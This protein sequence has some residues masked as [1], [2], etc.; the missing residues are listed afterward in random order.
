MRR[1]I[2]ALRPEWD[3]Q[4]KQRAEALIKD[5]GKNY[6]LTRLTTNP[7]LLRLMIEV[8]C[9]SE[10]ISR[11]R[12]DLYRKYSEETVWQQREAARNY[13]INDRECALKELESIA[14]HL[15]LGLQI[16]SQEHIEVLLDSGLIS[17]DN[18]KD[19]KSF[20]FTHKTFQQYFV[21]RYLTHL[22]ESEKSHKKVWL[23]IRS[24]I[25]KESWRESLLLTSGMI[26]S[27]EFIFGILRIKPKSLLAKEIEWHVKHN[28]ILAFECL[29]ECSD[30][31]FH[32]TE[33]VLTKALR[34]WAETPY[35]LQRKQLV[36][37]LK[38]FGD[39]AARRVILTELH[40][41]LKKGKLEKRAYAAYAISEVN[42][43]NPEITASLLGALFISRI[44]NV[45][46]LRF[47]KYGLPY[48]YFSWTDDAERLRLNSAYC[49]GELPYLGEEVITS[50]VKVMETDIRP[51]VRDQAAES[52]GKLAQKSSKVIVSWLDKLKE[53]PYLV[54]LEDVEAKV[55]KREIESFR[56][57]HFSSSEPYLGSAFL[58]SQVRYQI[59]QSYKSNIK[60]L[61]TLLLNAE[62]NPEISEILL[63]KIEEFEPKDPE[64]FWADTDRTIQ[65]VIAAFLVNGGVES[66]RLRSLLGNS[67]YY[68]DIVSQLL[69]KRSQHD[70][71]A[72]AE[73]R[74]KSNEG[75]LS[76]AQKIIWEMGQ[77][78][79][80][81]T[82]TINTLIGILSGPFN[83]MQ[84]NAAESLEKIGISSPDVIDALVYAL[85][86]SDEPK[87]SHF[88][89]SA[90]IKALGTLGFGYEQAIDALIFALEQGY[91]EAIWGLGR[92]GKN[93]PKA[94]KALQKS[95]KHNHPL[96]R[97]ASAMGLIFVDQIDNR[98]IKLVI[99]V[100]LS[101]S[102]EY[103]FWRERAA[104]ALGYLNHKATPA[105]I[106]ALAKALGTPDNSRESARYEI[107]EASSK[108]LVQLG[109][110][111]PKLV[112]QKLVAILFNPLLR[113][114]GM[115]NHRISDYAYEALYDVSSTTIDSFD[116]ELSSL[117][118]NESDA[119]K[120]KEM[121]LF[122][123]GSIFV[124][125]TLLLG[126][127]LLISDI[128][129][130]LLKEQWI[131]NLK[132]W[133]I[134]NPI[135]ILVIFGLIA[136]IIGSLSFLIDYMKK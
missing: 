23:I 5:L 79:E 119:W 118:L 133:T 3:Q 21:A 120:R 35:W 113:K 4:L 80:P 115:L 104:I 91:T 78:K 76:D 121:P 7:L 51:A 64:D 27:R 6:A 54:T 102:E 20:Y 135:Q 109:K 22:W 16:P 96:V 88:V 8:Y 13:S 87:G 75:V 89:R 86:N 81:N 106:T 50:L 34:L 58:A 99:E 112:A 18:T 93:S 90:C 74:L 84:D 116:K 98:V 69:V 26:N 43:I 14:W 32:T 105:A 11:N 28:Q 132:L 126:Y 129:T 46:L 59:K 131:Q 111:F 100:L 39:D 10:Q 63:G 122:L 117:D 40:K 60:L 127:S 68:P 15:Q 82:E 108:S 62:C 65:Q 95:L 92:I 1:W 83:G 36:D 71:R 53:K 33:I 130:E 31:D 48:L 9:Q 56:R 49:L 17:L 134:A 55:S 85:Y 101:N 94:V 73:L 24:C 47:R 70:Q 125:V 42:Q 44:R 19:K 72:M 38:D 124:L 37:L 103:Q 123:R 25:Y 128:L 77:L 107:W 66:D 110:F 30:I 97:I 114:P 45:V 52:L 136:I 2:K 61:Q 29:R 57:K 12:V 41:H 67:R